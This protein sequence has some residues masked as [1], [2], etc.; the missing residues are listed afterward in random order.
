MIL[1]E[2]RTIVR[3]LP[4]EEKENESVSEI[5]IEEVAN[6]S[7]SDGACVKG[8]PR[9]LVEFDSRRSIRF[10]SERECFDENHLRST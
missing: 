3:S 6:S 2:S 10:D 1:G 9:H 7:D 8:S 4:A 5:G